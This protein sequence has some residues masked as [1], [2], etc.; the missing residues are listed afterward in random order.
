MEFPDEMASCAKTDCKS[1]ESIKVLVR[2]R[3]LSDKESVDNND[4]VVDIYDQQ[5]LLV[6]SADKK[7]SFQ[8]SFDS[9]LGPSTSQA[10]VYETVRGC[11]RSVLDGFNSTIFAY[12]QTGSGKVK[13]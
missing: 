11:T 13:C 2:V 10:E 12:G 7:K 4:S 5:T 3:P 8:C 1:A 6:T 9:V